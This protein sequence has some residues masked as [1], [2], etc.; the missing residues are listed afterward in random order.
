M[1]PETLFSLLHRWIKGQRMTHSSTSFQYWNPLFFLPAN[2]SSYIRSLL[3]QARIR[4]CLSMIISLCLVT[5]IPPLRWISPYNV[6]S[7]LY[8]FVHH[9]HRLLGICGTSYNGCPNELSCSHT[10]YT[11]LSFSS[12]LIARRLWRFLTSEN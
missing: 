11:A 1:E 9:R 5:G 2:L 3:S 4:Y 12:F 8:R 6:P 10:V 7:I